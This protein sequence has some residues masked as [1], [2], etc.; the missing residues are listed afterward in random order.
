MYDDAY[1]YIYITFTLQLSLLLIVIN[2]VINCE[3]FFYLM[4]CDF[5]FYCV[6][7]VI[8]NFIFVPYLTNVSY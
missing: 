8:V 1:I 6:H 4:D 2:L 3:F 7:A 5:M